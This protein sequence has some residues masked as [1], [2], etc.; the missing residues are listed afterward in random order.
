[1]GINVANELAGG[2]E[3][4]RD[5]YLQIVFGM[6][7]VYAVV[8]VAAVALARLEGSSFALI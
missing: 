5:T 6:A 1:M 8:L 4:L 2:R 7:Y 3:R